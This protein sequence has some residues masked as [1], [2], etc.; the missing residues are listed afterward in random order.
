MEYRYTRR[1]EAAVCGLSYAVEK[2]NDLVSG[3][4][5]TN[6]VAE[7]GTGGLSNFFESVTNRIAT[8]DDPVGFLR[9]KVTRI[10]RPGEIVWTSGIGKFTGTNGANTISLNGTLV[11]A[12]SLGAVSNAP[13]GAVTVTNGSKTE[14]ILFTQTDTLLNQAGIRINTGIDTGNANWDSVV[15]SADWNNVNP[16]TLTLSG[17]TPGQ[18]YQI[19][20]FLFDDRNTTVAARIQTYSDGVMESLG[21]RNDN[22]K[23]IIGTFIANG[24]SQSITLIGSTTSVTLNAYILRAISP[25]ELNIPVE[26]D[27]VIRLW[28]GDA[29]GL[30]TPVANPETVDSTM[31]FRAVSVPNLWVYLPDTP[32]Q[33]RP[34]VMICPGGGFGSVGMGLH[35][36]NAVKQFNDQGIAVI[37]LKYRTNYGGNNYVQDSLAD[38][39]RA[40]RLIRYHAAGWGIDPNRICVQGYSAGGTVCMNLLGNFDAGNAG[41]SDPVERL[42]S[43]PDYVALMC[44]WP[45]S[46]TSSAYPMPTNP[47]PAF[48]ASAQDDTV[49]PTSFALEIGAALTNQGG[50]VEWFIV[51]TGGHSAFHY[52]VSTSPGAE[53]PTALKAVFP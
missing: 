23:S 35:V 38:S 14:S 40:M 33:N 13:A 36:I 16:K 9:L 6:G 1:A 53:W 46:R 3:E 5:R 32:A 15:N 45:N 26:P 50:T 8:Q 29:P 2:S 30:V 25:G 24:D 37:G 4:W 31:A 12:V 52:G 34:A 19:E 7:I 51:P 41:S 49:A 21:F 42:S 18:A 22:G 48:I 43:R 44:P 47:P 28:A 39:E 10:G 27:Q 20:L 11:E 17:L